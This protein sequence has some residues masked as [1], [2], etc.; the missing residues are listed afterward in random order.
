M[1]VRRRKNILQDTFRLGFLSG[2]IASVAGGD[3]SDL[4]QQIIAHLDSSKSTIEVAVYEISSTE[5][6][7]ALIRA[8]RRGIQV[9]VLVDGIRSTSATTQ[10]NQIEDERIP[11]RRLTAQ[12]ENLLHDKFILF[13]GS[14]A[15]T[16]SYDRSIRGLRESTGSEPSFTRDKD[17][18]KS[19][20]S[21]FENLW[22]IAGE[23]PDP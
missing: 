13:D 17:E 8:A 20:K 14:L 19:L 9:R 10:E 12:G 6:A 3:G 7:D 11:L 4:R 22:R 15:A 23:S 5:M 2:L 21:K 16:P 18:V 1:P